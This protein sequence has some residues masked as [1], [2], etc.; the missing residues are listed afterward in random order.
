MIV[1]AGHVNLS[2]CYCNNFTMEIICQK[3][4]LKLISHE[5]KVNLFEFKWIDTI[6]ESVELTKHQL[7]SIRFHICI[8][9]ILKR[10]I[11]IDYP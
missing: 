4:T 5:M 7:K 11:I 6:I 8:Q 10:T 2:I 9:F 3:K 1:N